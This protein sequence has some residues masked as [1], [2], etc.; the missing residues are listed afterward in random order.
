MDRPRLTGGHR[1]GR[2]SREAPHG[3]PLALPITRSPTLNLA[4]R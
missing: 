1:L 2:R 3:T 4:L